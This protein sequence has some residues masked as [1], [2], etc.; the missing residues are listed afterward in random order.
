MILHE[1]VI[2]HILIPP[3]S[4]WYSLCVK[5]FWLNFH[6]IFSHPVIVSFVL[7][8]FLD[9]NIA[10]SKRAKAMAIMA[11]TTKKNKSYNGRR[12]NFDTFKDKQEINKNNKKEF[13]SIYKQLTDKTPSRVAPQSNLLQNSRKIITPSPNIS[14]AIFT[15]TT[16]NILAG[17][18]YFHHC[19]EM[20]T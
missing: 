15:P 19:F 11:S 8:Y 2:Y 7:F 17:I 9:T 20:I 3:Y 6:A 5:P 4:P 12:I 16:T 1:N 14:A 10:G 18:Q 13:D